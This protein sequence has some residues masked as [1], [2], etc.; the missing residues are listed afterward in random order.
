M[1]ERQGDRFRSPHEFPR[2]ALVAWSTH[3]LPTFVGWWNTKDVPTR[4]QFGILT[5]EQGQREREDRV[6]AKSALVSTLKAEGL[7]P[8]DTRADGEATEALLDGVQGLL[9]STPSAVMV[10]QMEDV[11]GIAEQASLPGT[12]DQHPNWRRKLPVA[13]EDLAG[14]EGFRRVGEAFAKTGRGD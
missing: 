14:H 12:V 13:L 5:T 7:V 2:R 11:L 9:A 1:F 6:H 4:E 10:V 8:Q 3:D